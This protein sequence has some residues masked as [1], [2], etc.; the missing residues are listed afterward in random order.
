MIKSVIQ[1][2]SGIMINVGA[3]VKDNIC[4]ND[5]IWNLATCSCRN[6]KYLSSIIDNLVIT[7]DEII[8]AEAKT[9]DEETKTV[10]TN[11]N[12]KKQHKKH[13]ISMFY[14]QFF[15]LL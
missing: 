7:Y 14:F 5:Y 4:E 9:Y 2:K 13:K 6:G 10:A 3:S 11:F 12:E 8:D 1:I 15:H